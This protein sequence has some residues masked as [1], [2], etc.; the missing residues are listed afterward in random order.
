[1]SGV[2]GIVNAVRTLEILRSF[3]EF[4]SQDQYKDVVTM[5]SLV[6][7]VQNQKVGKDI[8]FSL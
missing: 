4:L 1:M 7:E 2:M 3:T 6:N 5:L 8:I